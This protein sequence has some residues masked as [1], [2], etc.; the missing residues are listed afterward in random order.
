MLAYI[1][2]NYNSRWQTSW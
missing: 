2:S 1:K